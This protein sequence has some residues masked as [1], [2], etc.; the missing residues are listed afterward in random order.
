VTIALAFLSEDF[1]M[2]RA[3]K[4]VGAL[5]L[6]VSF[7]VN[8]RA[9]DRTNGT[10]K[11]ADT[12]RNEVV[13]KGI[14]KDTVYEL[15]KGAQVWLNGLRSK[16]GDLKAD[17]RA[18]VTYEKKGDHLMA[19]DVRALRNAKETTGTVKTTF[20]DRKEIT[21]KGLVKDTTYELNP[22]ATVWADGKKAT[23]A[24]IREGDQVLVTYE[25]RGDRLMAN[26]V[27]ITKRK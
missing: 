10:I 27:S 22:G 6:L 19:R 23:L 16:L 7:A 17:D 25:Q 15:D 13:L 8:V 4:F 26:D 9:E 20:A 24:D 1:V 18:V 12:T 21:L 11:S 14:V 3:I 2:V 5:V